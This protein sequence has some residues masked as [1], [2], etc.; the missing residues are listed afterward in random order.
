MLR[1]ISYL[2]FIG[3]KG[4]LLIGW[5]AGLAYYG[6]YVTKEYIAKTRIVIDIGISS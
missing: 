5:V 6:S 3:Y 2:G 1:V 4:R